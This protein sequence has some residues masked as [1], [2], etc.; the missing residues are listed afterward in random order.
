VDVG[1]DRARRSCLWLAERYGLGAGARQRCMVCGFDE[2]RWAAAR[3]DIVVAGNFAKFG[4][5]LNLR[6]FLLATGKKVLVEASPNDQ[7]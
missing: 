5:H 4:Q 7:I 6:S 3:H 2:P 1:R